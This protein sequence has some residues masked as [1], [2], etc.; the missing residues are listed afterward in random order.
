MYI[1]RERDFPS[2]LIVCIVCESSKQMTAI[3]RWVARVARGGGG[4]LQK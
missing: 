2:T 1:Y 4:S 3:E